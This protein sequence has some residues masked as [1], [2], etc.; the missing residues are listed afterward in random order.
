[1]I[2]SFPMIFFAPYAGILIDKK[3]PRFTIVLGLFL[4]II[5]FTSLTIFMPTGNLILISL[6]LITFGFGMI[7]TMVSSFNSGV[8]SVPQNKRGAASG[9][10]NTFRNTGTSLGV[11]ILG[12]IFSH[13]QFNRFSHLLLRKKET[14][15][16]DPNIFEGLLSNT[17]KAINAFKSLSSNIQLSVKEALKSSYIY[18]ITFSNLFAAFIIV[19]T[20]CIILYYFKPK[21]V[22]IEEEFKSIEP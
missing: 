22:K 7:L 11:A 18:G 12:A 19:V 4:L 1:M 10:L 15:N 6:S 2:S 20:F 14:S 9:V 3:G 21:K 13:S 8:G 16:L 5:A 17:S